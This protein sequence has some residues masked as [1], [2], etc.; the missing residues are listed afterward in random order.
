VIEASI[1]KK[2]ISTTT[3]N[4]FRSILVTRG[5]NQ[6]FENVLLQFLAQLCAMHETCK[7]GCK[8]T[9][10]QSLL[11]KMFF[12]GLQQYTPVLHARRS[13]SGLPIIRPHLVHASKTQLTHGARVQGA[14]PSWSTAPGS[15]LGPPWSSWG[16]LM[17]ET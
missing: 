12:R 16:S 11:L 10:K 13:V 14:F 8:R 17:T 15:S 3:N 7:R 5:N 4:V 6:E 2:I 9:S 1:E